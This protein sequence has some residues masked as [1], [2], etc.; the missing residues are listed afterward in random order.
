ME[1][2]LKYILQQVNEWLKFG[3]AK[4]AA[5]LAFNLSVIFGVLKVCNEISPDTTWI[6]LLV[7]VCVTFLMLSSISCLISYVP[8]LKI[9]WLIQNDIKDFRNRNI[10]YF[11]DIAKLT[12]SD[13]IEAVIERTGEKNEPNHFQINLSEQ[14]VVNSKIALYKYTI[15]NISLWLSISAIIT[16][17]ISLLLYFM[18]K[19][20]R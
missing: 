3:E 12:S 9:K 5:L 11:G 10:L 2:K 4:N 14:I 17:L 1:E 16:P 6:L 18:L 7:K 13:L 20:L 8:Q 15:F 19:A